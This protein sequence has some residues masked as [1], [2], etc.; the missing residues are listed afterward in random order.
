MAEGHAVRGTLHLVAVFDGR[1][2]SPR[3][4]DG[5]SVNP[6]CREARGSSR[7]SG[8][9]SVRRRRVAPAVECDD[10]MAH[11]LLARESGLL[12]CGQVRANGARARP[13]GS[14][15]RSAFDPE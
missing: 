6:G 15:V 2:I 8:A 12:E 9:V 3:E 4:I 10:A 5:W 7:R 14:R 1:I 13:G 11:P